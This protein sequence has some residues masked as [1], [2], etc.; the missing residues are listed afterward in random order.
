MKHASKLLL[1]ALLGGCHAVQHYSAP[2]PAGAVDCAARAAE[3]LGYVRISPA[4][5][6][7]VRLRQPIDT[8]LEGQQRLDP[9]TGRPVDVIRDVQ[10]I[11]RE[12]ELRIRET[13]GMLRIEIL[14]E[15]QGRRLR[16]EGSNATAHAQIILSRCAIG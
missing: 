2:A 6:P 13:R 15:G 16:E 4:D 8:P 1:A 14:S 10:H 9:V 11:P 12:N 3:E 5:E 7:A